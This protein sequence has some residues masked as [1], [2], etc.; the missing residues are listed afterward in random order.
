MQ[1]RGWWGTG[2]RPRRCFQ[3]ELLRPHF[4]CC[5]ACHCH[6]FVVVFFRIKRCVPYY[7]ILRLFHFIV[8]L[9]CLLLHYLCRADVVICCC[10]L[11]ANLVLIYFVLR[12]ICVRRSAWARATKIALLLSLRG[13]RMDERAEWAG[14]LMKWE[15]VCTNATNSSGGKC[16]FTNS[17]LQ[18][19]FKATKRAE[20][21]AF[22]APRNATVESRLNNKSASVSR[23]SE[24]IKFG[25]LFP[26][27]EWRAPAEQAANFVGSKYFYKLSI[28]CCK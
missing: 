18:Q 3:R 10:C 1:R 11:S 7:Y 17:K 4:S 8:F 20:A 21:L 24:R 9:I 14:R 22:K 27:V 16:C 12:L 6:Y 25:S 28:C 5:S 2:R 19:R 15:I 13:S 26:I 23:C